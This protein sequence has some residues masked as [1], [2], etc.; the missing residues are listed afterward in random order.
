MNITVLTPDRAVF[1]GAI[2]SVKVPGTEG[3]FQ[4]LANHAA[5]V[6]SLGKGNVSLV[7]ADGSRM[8]FSITR[9]FI[10]VLRN[11]V[12]LLVQGVKEL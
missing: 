2:T 8:N 6:S 7:K 5:L 4:I 12:S 3:E 10:E 1:S 11:E 9:G